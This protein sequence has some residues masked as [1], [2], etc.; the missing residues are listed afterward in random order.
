MRSGAQ[1]TLEYRVL[2]RT[3]LKV[4]AVSLGTVGLGLEYGIRAPGGSCRPP[5]AEALALLREA[6]GAGI[7]FFDTAPGYGE[8]ER[9]LGRFLPE[10]PG[11][12]VATKVPVPKDADGALLG[13][14]AARRAVEASVEASLRALGRNVLDVVQVHNAT[15][16]AVS[17]GEVAEAL[18]SARRQGKVRFLGA[19]VYT[20][21]EALAVIAAGCFDVLQVPYNLLDQRMAEK[22][23]PAAKA[24]GVGIVVRSAFLK[25][26]LTEKAR[27]LPPELAPL[28]R[29]AERAAGDFGASWDSLPELALRFCLSDPRVSTTLTGAQSAEELSRSLAAAAAGPLPEE[30]LAKAA[31]FALSDDRLLNPSRW[32]AA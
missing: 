15:V 22:V 9:L 4:S 27:W 2:G 20:G 6:A 1:K 3:G 25:G 26:A 19:S 29:A 17:R 16:E 32:P 10:A 24:A 12:F 7:N 31:G 8:S 11:C 13:G 23:F 28:K 18:Q 30:L 5:E 21:E 14:P